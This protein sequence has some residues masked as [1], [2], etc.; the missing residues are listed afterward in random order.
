MDAQ[1]L[2][3]DRM[4]LAVVELL[5]R[6]GHVRQFVPVR[7][8][9]VTIGRAVDCDVV[10]DDPHAAPHH[11]SVTEVD[12]SLRLVVDETLNGVSVGRRQYAARQTA[13]LAAG[14]VLEIGS[15]RLSLRRAADPLAPERSIAADA[16]VRAL[17][18]VPLALVYM[19]LIAGRYW[20]RVDP[21]GRLTD[22]LLVVV[23]S[24]LALVVWT[25]FWAVG[26]KLVRH[27]F[28]LKSHARIAL[29]YTLGSALIAT[30]LPLLAFAIG[31]AFPSRVS[32]I[33]AA[34]VICAM[35][36]AHLTLILPARRRFLAVTMVLLFPAGVSLWVART[37]QNQER[38]FNE[39][40]VTT[41]APPSLRLAPAESAAQFISDARRLKA[42]LDVHVHDDR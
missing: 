1:V 5:D 26:S 22:Y 42:V 32:G 3:P 11:A 4:K 34:G 7:Q 13:E 29:S 2:G 41:M 21:G 10:L 18:V 9:P 8:W 38:F 37:Y 33:A 24:M 6:D 16:H 23:G 40:Y 14:D 15:T 27:R 39:L 25:G 19:A 28:D 17:P 12:G 31:V 20:V 35:V 36:L 30:I